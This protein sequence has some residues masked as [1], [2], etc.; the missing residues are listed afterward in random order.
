[1]FTLNK[2]SYRFMQPESITNILIRAWKR[3]YIICYPSNNV[4]FFLIIKMFHSIINKKFY[5]LQNVLVRLKYR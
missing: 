5:N 2:G 4:F 1:M 3:Y